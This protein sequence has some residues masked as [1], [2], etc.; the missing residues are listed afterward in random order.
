MAPTRR[1]L[2][3][4]FI[5]FL[6][7]ADMA[8]AQSIKVT[9]SDAQ[10]AVSA[11]R[12]FSA[13]VTGL[14]SSGVMW[15]VAGVKGGN[16]TN[17]TISAAGLF[18]APAKLPA[19]NPV[20]IT[21]ASTSN[22]SVYATV[23]VTILSEGPTLTSGSPNPLPE[24]NFTVTLKGDGFQNGAEVV[25]NG[26]QL[27]TSSVTSTTV[28]ATGYQPSASFAV[29]SVRNPGSAGSN[30]IKIPV[31]GTGGSGN[32]NFTLTVVSGSGSGTYS[33][34]TSINITA[35]SPPQGAKFESWVGAA[36]ASPTSTSTTLTM[37]SANTTVTATYSGNYKLTVV[38][39]TGSGSYA[40]GSPVAIKA[41]VPPAGQW[42]S[43]W[44]GAAVAS[45]SSSATTLIM[46]AAAT[47]V[48]ATYYTPPT[49][50]FP[51]TDHPRLWVNSSDLPKL[52]SWAVKSNP[53]YESGMLPLLDDAVS[54][55][56]TQFFPNGV[57]NPNYPDP[58]DTQGY[59][60]YLTEQYGAVLAF[61]SLIDPS[62]ANRIKYAQMA[63]NLLMVAMNQAA[64]GPLANAPF[65]DP[66]FAVY[67]RANGSGE[68]WPLIVDWIYSAKDSGG[69]DIL[70]SADK[71]TIRKVFMIWANECLNASTTGG[72]HPDPIGTVNDLSLLPGNLPYRMASNNY[73]L[74]HARLLTMMALS[75]D[76]ADDPS[77]DP[78]Q[79]NSAIGNSMRS[80]LLDALGAWL[81]Q[82][83]AMMGEPADIV[84]AYGISGTGA[85][86]GLSSGGLP[87]EGML[88]GHSFGFAL[89]QLLA[90]QTAGF[91]NIGYAGPQA[92]L[93]SSPV[94]DRYVHGY[95]SSMTPA[96][97]VYASQPYLGPCFEFGSYGDL[98][99][100]WVTPDVM[101]PFSL[102][103]LIEEK[104]GQTTHRDDARWMAIDGVEG[105]SGYLYNRITE[106]WSWSSTNSIL[107]F[108]LLDPS[109]AA[110]AD[111]R[112]G[113]PTY[114][115]DPAAGRIVAHTNWTGTSTMFDY[116]AS[117]ESIN[118]QDGDAGQFEIYRNG[119][120]LTKELSNYDDN[121][122][123][124][125]SPYHN[126]LGIQNWSGNGTPNL[127]WYE[128][129]MW[130]DGSQWPL[131]QSA[132]DPT[133]AASLGTNY[134][135]ANSNLTPLYNLPD[136]WD[137][138]AGAT[139]VTQ[140]TRTILWLNSDYVVVYDRA[141]TQHSGLFKNFNLSFQNLPAIKGNVATETLTSG[142]QLFVQTLLPASA[143]STCV[144]G[145][146]KLS[147]V[148]ILEPT[149]YI[150]TVSDN[151]KPTDTRFL[152]VL[153]AASKGTAMV[154]ASLAHS[155]S[156]SMFDGAVFGAS[157]AFFPHSAT[158]AFVASTFTLPSAVHTL[159]LSG[160]APGKTYGLT[161]TKS[162]TGSTVVV[163]PSGSGASAD[164]AGLLV[165]GL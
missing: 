161:V 110:P 142:Q 112:P 139:D 105:G 108:L 133:T 27:S 114:F 147:S 8:R 31:T 130:T 22:T 52:R 164:S 88:Y 26:V 90:L 6:A 144:N 68:Q 100:L 56:N 69:N 128:T 61:N 122:F 94:W 50:P 158:F 137:T 93:I 15:S 165:I 150:Y 28:V 86:F 157:A 102:L 98:L 60:G 126:T 99:R 9:P 136:V 83:Y 155:T 121:G 21:A 81:Y 37:P 74:G 66:M 30:P 19:Q 106:P 104:N 143:A 70:T 159:Y 13:T 17:G 5:L 127:S 1:T 14:S 135:Y 63:R 58:G 29:F 73:Y 10:V 138:A 23:Y 89:G 39:G 4:I 92:A 77:V 18:T 153:Q 134:V 82:E 97:Q 65:R 116:R 146:S 80:Y 11:A 62:A 34:G 131:A 120:W 3:S 154:V 163:S 96:A 145:A 57:Q 47:T 64:L 55:Y 95:F 85:G 75:I 125:S 51:V 44:R 24:G 118:H 148:A 38:N 115:F 141:T 16:S 48:T 71:A 46:P 132:G 78:T 36:V 129:G 109:L 140:A 107:Y 113:F 123:G 103:A 160:L 67:N 111:P 119:E 152:H 76:P 54:V 87:P 7:L 53:I 156:G 43:A 2:F 49:I 45:T 42:F 162:A 35:N 12:Q 151:S 41:N 40:S 20:A 59:T 124:Q 91:N 101:Q 79:P 84:K 149:Q 33:P 117:W 25:D 72:D 32:G